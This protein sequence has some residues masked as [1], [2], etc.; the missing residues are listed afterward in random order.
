M[1]FFQLITNNGVVSYTLNFKADGTL[2][3]SLSSFNAALTNNQNSLTWTTASENNSLGFEVES[4]TEGATFNKIGFVASK[5]DGNSSSVLTYSFQDKLGTAVTTYYRL[6]QVDKDGKSTYS[7]IKS[8]KNLLLADQSTFT[9][10]PN[11]T[12]DYVNIAG[13]NA[14]GVTVQLFTTAGTEVNTSKLL[15]ADHLNMTSLN[16]GVY[17]LRVSKNGTLL[18]TTCL[19]KQ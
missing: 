17:V 8:V 2:P 10:Y 14:D 15:N 4:I 18:Q 3:V 12:S 9:V 19:V 13:A 7:E 6:K 5:N 16:P 1:T 11:P